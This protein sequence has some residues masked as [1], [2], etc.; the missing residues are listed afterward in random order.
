MESGFVDGP[1]VRRA[2]F[3][4]LMKHSVGYTLSVSYQLYFSGV[5]CLDSDSG[6]PHSGF[7]RIISEPA[8]AGSQEVLNETEFN[9]WWRNHECTLQ[10]TLRCCTWHRRR[11]T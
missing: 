2:S 9:P 11:R 4:G 3:C 8:A 6:F 10:L 7:R 1:P 5:K